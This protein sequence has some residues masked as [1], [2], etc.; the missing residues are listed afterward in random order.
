MG[1]W[2]MTSFCL[3]LPPCKIGEIPGPSVIDPY[4]AHHTPSI[5]HL[6]PQCRPD[7]DVWARFDGLDGLLCHLVH[8]ALE[9]N[10][11]E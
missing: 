6:L 1:E 5:L 3:V 11:V 7:A 2:M 10:G 4:G 8:G 9:V